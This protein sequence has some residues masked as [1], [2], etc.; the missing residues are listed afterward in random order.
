M[1]KVGKHAFTS[2]KLFKS[3]NFY[4]SNIQTSA[5]RSGLSGLSFRSVRSVLGSGGKKE[6]GN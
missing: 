5:T 2:K 1:G 4:Y 3:F 6:K